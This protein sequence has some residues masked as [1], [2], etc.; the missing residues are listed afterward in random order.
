MILHSKEGA[1]RKL[2]AKITVLQGIMRC[3]FGLRPEMSL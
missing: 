2:G 3:V 1:G